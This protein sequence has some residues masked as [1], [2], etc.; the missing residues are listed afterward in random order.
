MNIKCQSLSYELDNILAI[1]VESAIKNITKQ[2]LS[3]FSVW[4]IILANRV[5]GLENQ[6]IKALFLTMISAA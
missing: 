5:A 2:R 4:S 1:L 6:T 3:I